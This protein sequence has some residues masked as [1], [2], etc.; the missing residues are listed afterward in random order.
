MLSEN[1]KKCLKDLTNWRV[2]L[3]VT[4]MS[5]SGLVITYFSMCSFGYLHH[6]PLRMRQNFRWRLSGVVPYKGFFVSKLLSFE[7]F[8]GILQSTQRFL[9]LL[10]QNLGQES[11]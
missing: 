1:F 8:T 6:L 11:A 5:N 4:V 10:R 2:S 9:R 7:R 3:P